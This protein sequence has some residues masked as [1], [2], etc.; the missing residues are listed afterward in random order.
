MAL[1]PERGINGPNGPNAPVAV[2]VGSTTVNTTNP[3]AFAVNVT[4]T[5]SVS[6]AAITNVKVNGVTVGSVGGVAYLVPAGATF[7]TTYAS[8]TTTYAT[9]G[10]GG[11]PVIV[12][13]YPFTDPVFQNFNAQQYLNYGTG[14]GPGGT[15]LVQEDT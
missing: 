6:N 7:Q 3:N 2:P 4:P 14:T 10:N 15:P 5:N 11:S 13:Q 1:V 9:S 8:G 12:S